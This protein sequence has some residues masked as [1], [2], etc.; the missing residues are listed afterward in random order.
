VRESASSIGSCVDDSIHN[1]TNSGNEIVVDEE[2][3]DFIHQSMAYMSVP[4]NDVNKEMYLT[5]E[6]ACNSLLG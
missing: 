6:H 1:A 4:M 5:T 3:D 2:T